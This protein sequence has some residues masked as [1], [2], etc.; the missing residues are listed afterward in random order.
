MTDAKFYYMRN[1]LHGLPDD[2]AVSVLKILA[3]AMSHESRLVIDDLVIPD[4]GACRQACQLDFIMMASI[5]GKKRTRSQWFKIVEA[6]GLKINS[7]TIYS[8]PLQDSL[9][10]ASLPAPVG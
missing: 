8:R 1:V 5:A 6:A 9:I 7:I 4:V 10:M 3:S 2:H